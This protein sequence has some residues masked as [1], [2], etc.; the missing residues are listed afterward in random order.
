MKVL[1][2]TTLYD[3]ESRPDLVQDTS[4]IHY[5]LK[6]WAKE[7]EILVINTYL[8]TRK[9]LYR[10]F[11]IHNLKQYFNDYRFVKDN[12]I[13]HVIENQVTLGRYLQEWDWRRIARRSRE[14]LEQE[15]FEPDIVISHLPCYSYGFI[16]RLGLQCKKVGVMHLTDLQ[17]AQMKRQ[18]ID[19][20]NQ[21]FDCVFARSRQIRDSARALGV[22]KLSDEIVY[23][24]APV[25][26]NEK[27]RAWDTAPRSILY[28]GKL[29]SRKRIEWI[30]NCL[31][32]PELS[33]VTL[34]IVGNGPEE[35]KLKKLAEKIGVEARVRFLGPRSREQVLQEMQKAEIFCMPS[36]DETFGL[37]YIEAMTCGC[38]TIGT[39]NEGIDG[40]IENG[41]N[42]Y[43]IEEETEL[44]R[45][46]KEIIKMD[47][48][49]IQKI[50]DNARNTGVL[51]SEENVSKQYFKLISDVAAE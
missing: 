6:Y 24:G 41:E 29:I 5:L 37:V 17:H 38:I 14:I 33:E 28:A 35:K 45:C 18:Y 27:K 47:Q 44:L 3:L 30:I 15:Q 7:N 32:D 19:G 9:Y 46:L 16:D 4:A 42:G 2:F 22:K 34:T 50:S 23:S 51:F 36:Y 8:N 40:V 20:L 43:L 1:V 21:H 11:N 25:I 13:V 48:S 10:Y 26:E 49:K 39:R 12:V 31:Q